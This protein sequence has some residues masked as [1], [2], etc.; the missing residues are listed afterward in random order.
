MFNVLAVTFSRRM[1]VQHKKPAIGPRF[2]LEQIAALATSTE[3]SAWGFH[4]E[5]SAGNPQRPEIAE[6]WR[7]HPTLVRFF[8][9]PLPG[10]D[11]EV[12]DVVRETYTS[13]P[14]QAVLASII[15]AEPVAA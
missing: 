3:G 12:Y 9:T 5:T 7:H 15:E 4:V 6:V 8:I 14:I 1:P 11:V 13:D 10:G 2:T